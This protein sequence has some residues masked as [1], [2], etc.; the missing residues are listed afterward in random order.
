MPDIANLPLAPARAYRFLIIRT[1]LTGTQRSVA[2]NMAALHYS[3]V[4]SA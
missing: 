2:L 3:R 1:D 4:T